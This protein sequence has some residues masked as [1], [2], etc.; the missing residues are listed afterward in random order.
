[1][2]KYYYQNILQSQNVTAKPDIVWVADIT[3]LETVKNYHVFLCIDAHTNCIV[4][5]LIKPSV[6]DS[7]SI[8]RSLSRAIEKRF[9][10]APK[11]KLILHTDRGTQFSS[12]RY[13]NF[14]KKY[15]EYVVPSMTR[16]NTPT[17]NAVA[18][19]FMRTFKE[20]TD[21]KNG[22]PLTI[23]EQM[24]SH[25]TTNPEFRSS[26]SVL[27]K[28]VK[29]LNKRPNKKTI[30]TSPERYDME[31]RVASQL[32]VEPE[33]PKAFSTHFGEDSRLDYISKYK[34]E[35]IQISNILAEI[36]AK[37][38]EVVS[39]TPFDNFD[40]NLELQLVH[41]RLNDIHRL[42]ENN[43]DITKTFVEE[44]IQPIEE[45][46]DKLHLKVDKLLPNPKKQREIL[47]LRDPT[48]STIFSI[49]KVN[50]GNSFKQQRNLKRAQ[51]RIL[52][53]ILYH[54]GLRLNEA[55]Y[56]TYD[57]I[58]K[59]IN[60]SQLSIIH[61]KTKTPHIHILSKTSL[62][63]LKNLKTEYQIVFQKYQFKYLFGKL[64]PIA[65]K[66]LIR[67]V[68]RDL[69]HTCEIANIPFNIKSHSFRINFISSLLK[70]T[71]VQNVADII[72]HDDIRSTLKYQR[73]ALE[74]EEVQKLLDQINDN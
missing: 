18:E 67:L 13:N 22:L 9:K 2:T 39:Q 27:N 29:S 12:K 4:A 52:Y 55:R 15:E 48:T 64:K 11:T 45:S 74:K 31:A 35:R 14:V 17:D 19:R 71:S 30:L 68:N 60:S 28:Y 42:L 8:I 62:N 58:E 38:A 65:E 33:H 37:Q 1:M 63:D 3:T 24:F 26:R 53:T 59:S 69:K 10:G 50:A 16:E 56:L 61:H 7:S 36:A 66:S 43:Y 49:F 47:P 51:L 21:E 54:V 25:I 34:N 70:V 41:E 20:H 73:Y 5:H 72:G 46:L 40:D 44:A 57:D 23:S 32:M 6:I